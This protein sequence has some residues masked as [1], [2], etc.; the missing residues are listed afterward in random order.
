MVILDENKFVFPMKPTLF[1]DSQCPLCR[2]FAVKLARD[3]SD[4]LEFKPLFGEG[5][6]ELHYQNEKGNF[7]GSEAVEQLVADIPEVQKYYW[8]LPSK[9]QG[10][11]VMTTYKWASWLRKLF[12]RRPC[13]KC[14]DS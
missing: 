11:A 9:Y 8:L 5:D 3:F 6:H 2:S 10:K 7:Y 12:F 14:P 4:Q 13:K 1:Y